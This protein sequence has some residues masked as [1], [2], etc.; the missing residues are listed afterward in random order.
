MTHSKV[1]KHQFYFIFSSSKSSSWAHSQKWFNHEPIKQILFH[2]FKGWKKI[3][4]L[5]QPS[6]K[7]SNFTYWIV[8]PPQGDWNV[9]YFILKLSVIH[10][11]MTLL[12][13]SALELLFRT[14]R[15]EVCTEIVQFYNHC[16]NVFFI[17][18]ERY[19]YNSMMIGKILC[20]D[21]WY[22]YYQF[23]PISCYPW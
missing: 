11:H 19:H 7:G 22:C 21:S 12:I 16:V 1:S 9:R 20:Y 6:R 2:F 18:R 14:L 3:F 4:M 15:G 10:I 23:I 5:L 13:S 17:Y 8:L